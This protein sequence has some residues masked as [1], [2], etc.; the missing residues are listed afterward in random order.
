METEDRRGTHNP[1]D[2]IP[3]NCFTSRR[4]MSRL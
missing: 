4:E 3:P 2:L 1:L